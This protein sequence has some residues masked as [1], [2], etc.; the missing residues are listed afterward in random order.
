[1]KTAKLGKNYW[2]KGFDTFIRWFFKTIDIEVDRKSVMET[3]W[4]HSPTLADM[5]YRVM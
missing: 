3:L 2:L 1:M 4:K 5:T